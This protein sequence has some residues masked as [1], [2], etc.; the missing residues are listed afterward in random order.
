VS[1][2]L[3]DTNVVV[4]A[5]VFGGK[6]AAVLQVV[7][8]LGIEVVISAELKAE[9]AETL[10]TKF[11]WSEERVEEACSRLFRNARR[12]EPQAL[13]GVVRDCDDDHV[14]AAAVEGGAKVIITGDKDLLDLGDFRGIRILTPAAF[15]ELFLTA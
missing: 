13:A 7:E 11:G 12:V 10:V 15:L 4:S 9:L 1:R 3:I 14:I 5:L 2:V 8:A 6:P